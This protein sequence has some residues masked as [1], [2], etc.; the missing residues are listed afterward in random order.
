M[1]G[2]QLVIALEE[3]CRAERGAIEDFLNALTDIVIERLA[4][5]DAVTIGNLCRLTVRDS[6]KKR[7]IKFQATP[8]AIKALG[9]RDK[10]DGEMCRACG[11]NKRAPGR[12]Y[13]H[14]CKHK[15]RKAQ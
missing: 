11:K 5:G 14:S 15:R 8:H 7:A 2:H 9:L 3:E 13:C 1:T 12:L 6:D 4:R 10:Y